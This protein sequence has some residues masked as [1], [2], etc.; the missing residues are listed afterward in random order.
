LRTLDVV[1]AAVGIENLS[2]PD[3]VVSDDERSRAGQL[4]GQRKYWS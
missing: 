1:V 4:Q 2:V 3:D